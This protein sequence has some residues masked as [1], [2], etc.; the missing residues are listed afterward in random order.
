MVLSA[1]EHH[2]VGASRG[3]ERKAVVF[4]DSAFGNTLLLVSWTWIFRPAAELPSV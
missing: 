3:S 4:V 2:G 1:E